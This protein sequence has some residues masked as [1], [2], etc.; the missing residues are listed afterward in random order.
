MRRRTIP[1]KHSLAFSTLAALL[2]CASLAACGGGDGNGG[3]GDAGGDGDGDGGGGGGG[4][5]C[6]KIDLLISVD[7]SGSMSEELA[8]M[9]SIFGDF[10]NALLNVNEEFENFRTGVIDSCPRPATFNTKNK[11]GTS[12]AFEG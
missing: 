2:T 6:K 3:D 5:A 4:A 7:P 12:C 11:A 1:M 10:A 9:S 8:A